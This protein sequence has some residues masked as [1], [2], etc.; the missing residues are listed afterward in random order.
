MCVCVFVMNEVICSH[1]DSVAPSNVT[2]YHVC[3]YVYTTDL[4]YMN[5][6]EM[7][8][9]T[10]KERLR[11]SI[12]KMLSHTTC[13]RLLTHAFSI[14]LSHQLTMNKCKQ[15]DKRIDKKKK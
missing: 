14:L 8:R 15:T 3:V 4:L 10:D 13:A 12:D 2:F 1:G 5:T 6:L 11:S 9:Q 7:D